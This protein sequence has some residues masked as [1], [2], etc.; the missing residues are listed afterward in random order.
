MIR[1]V[2]SAVLLLTFLAFAMSGGASGMQPSGEPMVHARGA[3]ALS[4]SQKDRCQMTAFCLTHCVQCSVGIRSEIAAPAGSA[5]I[6]A[7]LNRTLTKRTVTERVFR[8]PRA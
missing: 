8:P 5:S 4:K 3:A 2:T 7:E 6:K 1:A